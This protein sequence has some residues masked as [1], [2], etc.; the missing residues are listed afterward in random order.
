MPMRLA[1]L[2]I[3]PVSPTSAS[4]SAL[5]GPKAMSLPATM[6]SRGTREGTGFDFMVSPPLAHS[7][8]QPRKPLQADTRLEFWKGRSCVRNKNHRGAMK[9]FLKRPVNGDRHGG[10]HDFLKNGL[11]RNK[12]LRYWSGAANATG[13]NHPISHQVPGRRFGGNGPHHRRR[14]PGKRPQLCHLRLRRQGGERQ[15]HAARPRFALYVR[16]KNHRGPPVTK[17][18]IAGTIPIGRSGSHQSMVERFLRLS[19][20]AAV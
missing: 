8:T 5:P 3:E 14:H 7:R 19:R 17:G 10:G 4:N 16:P 12:R 18:W 13:P 11:P 2:A 1:A 9:H 6:R 15:T 20:R